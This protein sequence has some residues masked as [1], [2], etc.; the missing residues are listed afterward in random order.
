MSSSMDGT[1]SLC[2]CLSDCQKRLKGFGS[3]GEPSLGVLICHH[4]RSSFRYKRE[5]LSN[6]ANTKSRSNTFT[7][8]F[9]V[10]RAFNLF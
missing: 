6:Y 2:R 8:I 3:F 9:L 10:P 1:E 4:C 7:V 5:L